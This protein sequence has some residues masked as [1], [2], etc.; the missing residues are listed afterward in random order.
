MLDLGVL[1]IS[2]ETL[3][4]FSSFSETLRD[5]VA[6]AGVVVRSLLL[7]LTFL[8]ALESTSVLAVV[9]AN[10]FMPDCLTEMNSREFFGPRANRQKN[11]HDFFCF[12]IPYLG[13]SFKSQ[14]ETLHLPKMVSMLMSPL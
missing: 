10:C 7:L 5:R 4:S 9:S 12:P 1:T 13:T 3:A 14:I 2:R 8:E 6:R 11:T